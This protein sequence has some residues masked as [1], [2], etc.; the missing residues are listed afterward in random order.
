MALAR[1]HPVRPYGAAACSAAPRAGARA[2]AVV[3]SF[4]R[5]LG[6][7]A[8]SL[9]L[10][11]AALVA[12]MS[13]VRAQ[14]APLRDELILSL[15]SRGRAQPA[16]AAAELESLLPSTTEYSAQRLELLTV[17]G[18]MLGNAWQSDAAERSAARLDDWGRDQH[19]A[20]PA[21][22]AA[23]IRASGWARG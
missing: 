23:L 3:M 13:P 10:T 5:R 19:A 4:T 1:F 2:A 22:A 6:L 7:V 14:G 9:L 17:Q 18:L 11:A 21:A 15:E 12:G 16:Q 20:L 8:G